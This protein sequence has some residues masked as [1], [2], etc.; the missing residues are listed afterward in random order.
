MNGSVVLYPEKHSHYEQ[1]AFYKNAK[2]IIFCD[3]GAIYA[4]ILLPDLKAEVA[5]VAR[6]RDP[7]WNYK[8]VAEHFCGYGKPILWIDEVIAQYEFG[9]ETWNAAGEINWHNVSVTLKKQGFVQ[10]TF[11]EPDTTACE[12]VKKKELQQYIQSIQHKQLFL[13]YMQDLK[14]QYP[15]LPAS[16]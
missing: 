12:Y 14:K 16:F 1:L 9:M 5:I 2:K 15:L 3:G 8:E 13:D 4:S 11:E 10:F 6:R 7:R